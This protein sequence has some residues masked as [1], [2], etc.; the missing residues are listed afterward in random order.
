MKS[1]TIP[2]LRVEPKLRQAVERSLNSDETLS[3]FTEQALREQIKRRKIQDE[4]IAR[5]L[6]SRDK[7][8]QSG[9]Y[10]SAENVLAGLDAMLA[11]AEKS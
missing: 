2:A 7:A 8:R 3:S 11:K 5:G 1:A 9:E 4:F 10:Y 6:E